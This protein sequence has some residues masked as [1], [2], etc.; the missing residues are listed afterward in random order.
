MK[1]L[2][3]VAQKPQLEI[4]VWK[5]ELLGNPTFS[6]LFNNHTELKF[7]I[8]D[9]LFLKD[10]RIN[11]CH[12]NVFFKYCPKRQLFNANV[13]FEIITLY[14]FTRLNYDF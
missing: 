10:N 12:L 14:F 8:F 13:V 2:K 6:S 7:Y 9:K 4:T 1:L 5:T 3:H 11:V